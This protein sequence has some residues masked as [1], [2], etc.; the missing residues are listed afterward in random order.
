MKKASDDLFRL[1]KSL[2]KSEKG[3]FKKF[4][5]RNSP[6]GKSNYLT[7]FDAVESMESYDEDALKKKL[8][9]HPFAAQIPVYKVYLFNLILKSLQIYGSYDNTDTKL[10]DMTETARI[11]EKK[12]MPKE[13]LKILKKAKEIAY[14]YDNPK[15]LLDIL[16]LERNIIMVSHDKHILEKR[17][18]IYEEHRKFIKS[19]SSRFHYTWLS[20]Q[21][22]IYLEQKGDVH[23]RIREE[24]MEKI[25][26]DPLMKSP[27]LAEGFSS[28]VFYYH[29]HLFYHIAKQNLSKMH[30]ITKEHIHLQEQHS[31]FINENPKN[32]IS[33]LLN[34]L[35]SS[36][37]CR[38]REDVK[39][40]LAKIAQARRLYRAKLSPD[41]ETELFIKAKNIE[42]IIYCDRGEA[43]K[44]MK[45]ARSVEEDLRK[46]RKFLNPSITAAL[47]YNAS[48]TCF[49]SG[50]YEG[51]L[52]FVNK[53]LNDQ[54]EIRS[55]IFNFAKVYNLLVHFELGHYDHLEYITENTR[56]Y[57]KQHKA[58][59]KVEGLLI[60]AIRQIL[61]SADKKQEKKIFGELLN[62]LKKISGDVKSRQ[63]FEFFDAI[64]WAESKISG[65]SLP[66][67]K[68]R[69]Y[70]SPSGD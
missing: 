2:S 47:L 17:K 13:A 69:K 28:K 36:H 27:E 21:M 53:L 4:A 66:H 70:A 48:C 68:K 63:A 50:D 6:G 54:E 56:R 9:D 34:Y 39:D 60:N 41:V 15:A 51:A 24:K 62:D 22:V 12:Q 16:F 65:E 46:Y 14:K 67:I 23:E 49:L 45:T 11:L 35:L 3:Y 29:T 52:Q 40:A 38:K 25:I 31:H 58:L 33:G 43:H 44:G 10:S 59:F 20:D 8:K 37:L 7:L 18:A 61:N 55:D 1:I 26:A 64:S 32:Y 42:L 30:E 57:L 5:A 19:L